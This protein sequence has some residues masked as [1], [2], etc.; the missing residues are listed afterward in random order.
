MTF[1]L[2]VLPNGLIIELFKMALHVHGLLRFVEGLEAN[3]EERALHLV[4]GLLGSANLLSGLVVT[5]FSRLPEYSDISGRVDL[6]QDHLKLVEETKGKASLLFHDF[7]DLP[8]VK[9]DIEISEGWLKF[10]KVFYLG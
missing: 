3:L 6:L 8:R 10:L 9:L 1:G 2:F 7:V 4:V 5:N